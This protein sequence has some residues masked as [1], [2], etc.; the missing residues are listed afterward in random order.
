MCDRWRDRGAVKVRAG[1]PCH[2]VGLSLSLCSH[3]FS[4][5]SINHEVFFPQWSGH[6][7]LSAALQGSG[8]FRLPLSDLIVQFRMTGFNLQLA[9]GSAHLV[10]L[11]SIP[12][13]GKNGE[14]GNG[15]MYSTHLP[16]SVI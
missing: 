7:P 2:T 1:L 10:P 11:Q 4:R 16:A 8:P 9:P 13:P 12:L 15:R 6:P 14:G 3:R 5:T